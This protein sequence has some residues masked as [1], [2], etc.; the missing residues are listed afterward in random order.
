VAA[1]EKMMRRESIPWLDSSRKSIEEIAATV[2]Q[3]L[4]LR[5][6]TTAPPRPGS[7]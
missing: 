5:V 7:A 6:K 3:E 2:L 1:A 4:D